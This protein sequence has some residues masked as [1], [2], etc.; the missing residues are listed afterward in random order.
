MAVM[1]HIELVMPDTKR[2]ITTVH[3]FVLIIMMKAHPLSLSPS[4]MVKF[5]AE[6]VGRLPNVSAA[7]PTA[8]VPSLAFVVYGLLVSWS[9]S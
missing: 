2:I 6:V 4:E 7:T 3:I 9:A 1:A 5:R 8:F